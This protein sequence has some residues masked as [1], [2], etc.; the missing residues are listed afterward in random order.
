MSGIAQ[1]GGGPIFM[2]ESGLQNFYLLIFLARIHRRFPCPETPPHRV[3]SNANVLGTLRS[4]VNNN[5]KS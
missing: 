3:H 4:T 1:K 2:P 5:N